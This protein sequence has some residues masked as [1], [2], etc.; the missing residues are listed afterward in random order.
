MRRFPLKSPPQ[1]TVALPGVAA[2]VVD[3]HEMNAA[4]LPVLHW[5]LGPARTAPFKFITCC[6]G[7]AVCKKGVLEGPPIII[8]IY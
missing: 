7:V 5:F 6:W 4:G 3:M 8:N 1:V 2:L